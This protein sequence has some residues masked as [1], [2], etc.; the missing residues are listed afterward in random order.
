MQ[1][2]NMH[3]GL[4]ECLSGIRTERTPVH[5]T[6]LLFHLRHMI[7]LGEFPDIMRCCRWPQVGSGIRLIEEEDLSSQDEIWQKRLQLEEI[8]MVLSF[9]VQDVWSL[10]IL[11]SDAHSMISLH[12]FVARDFTSLF[13]SNTIVFDSNRLVKFVKAYVTIV[14]MVGFNNI[15]SQVTRY[16]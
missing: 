6:L 13:E 1:I 9:D 5:I 12:T 10:D 15:I 8:L 4:S 7:W 2:E 11:C 14:I 3:L 16:A